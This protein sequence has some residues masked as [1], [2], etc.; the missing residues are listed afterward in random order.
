MY[1]TIS[2]LSLSSSLCCW[3]PHPQGPDP[4]AESELSKLL[5]QMTFLYFEHPSQVWKVH[6]N[7]KAHVNF[8]TG[9]IKKIAM[10]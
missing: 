2:K 6:L 1:G 9:F 3:P 8:L 5:F 4:E 7:L 10:D